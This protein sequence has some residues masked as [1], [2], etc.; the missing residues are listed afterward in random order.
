MARGVPVV[1]SDSSSLV[2][3]AGDCAILV[4]PTDVAE[5]AEGVHRVLT[6]RAAAA[7]LAARGLPR[8]AA[9]TWEATARAT[10]TAYDAAVREASL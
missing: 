9:Y 8:A 4:D 3:V 6:D 10:L 1:T 5:I 2:E 7:D